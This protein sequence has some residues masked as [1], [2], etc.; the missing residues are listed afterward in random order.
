MVTAISEAAGDSLRLGGF[1]LSTADSEA[2]RNDAA[3]RAVKDARSKAER[4]AD[5]AGVRLGRVVAISEM[6]APPRRLATFAAAHAASVPVEAGSDEVLAHVTV[7][8]EI[9]D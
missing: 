1:Q 4:V 3:A 2:A 7:I 9:A 5:A 6:P 8:F